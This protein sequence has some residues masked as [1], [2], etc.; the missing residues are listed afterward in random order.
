MAQKTVTVYKTPGCGG[1][2]ATTVRMR[3]KG[4]DHAVVDLS[5]DEGAMRA[6][7]SLGYSQAPVVVVGDGDPANDVHWTGFRPDLIEEHCLAEA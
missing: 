6:V 3:N 1:C 5:E 4:I 2:I 7:K